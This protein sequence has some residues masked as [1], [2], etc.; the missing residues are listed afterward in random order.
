MDVRFKTPANFYIYGQTQSGKSYFTS[1]MLRYLEELFY[2][3]LTKIIYCYGEYQK[4][5]DELLP[6]MEFPDHLNDM[7]CGHDHSL[8][9]LDD[10]MLQYF[11]DQHV[12]DL[13]T[14]G[15][16]SSRN[17]CAVLD[18]KFVSARYIIAHNQ[19]EFSL[20]CDFS[21]PARFVGYF[22]FGEPNVSRAYGLPCR[23]ISR[24]HKQTLWVLDDNTI[25]YNFI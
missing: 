12:A 10:L 6:S 16:A 8:V 19:F 3:V 1:C 17:I 25:Q 21:K 24:R 14:G 20:L 7:V 18:T 2:P 11:N 5:F 23:I 22:N 9:V 15:F 4:E 13:F